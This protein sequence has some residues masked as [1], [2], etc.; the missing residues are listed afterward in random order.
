MLKA[1]ARGFPSVVFD[2]VVGIVLCG[3]LSSKM[4][5]STGLGIIPGAR[6]AEVMLPLTIWLEPTEFVP[7][8]GLG[9]VPVKP[10]PAA[11]PIFISSFGFVSPLLEIV[12]PLMVIPLFPDSSLVFSA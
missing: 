6:S 9:Y 12:F 4:Y 1:F 7:M 10:P 3:Y 8:L 5:V 2:H 11:S